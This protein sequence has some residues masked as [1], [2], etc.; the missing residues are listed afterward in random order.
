MTGE[1]R[2]LTSQ[3]K[4]ALWGKPE[5]VIMPARSAIASYAIPSG[6]LVLA[7][8]LTG[9]P[10]WISLLSGAI[11]IG[12]CLPFVWADRRR[13]TTAERA[14]TPAKRNQGRP[15]AWLFILK[16]YIEM[17][18]SGSVNDATTDETHVAELIRA[19]WSKEDGAPPLPSVDTIKQRISAFRRNKIS[20]EH[21]DKL[22]KF[23]GPKLK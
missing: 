23:I 21:A 22:H 11:A 13:H 6:A 1:T 10:G 7:P 8:I 20:K 19:N 15:A 14:Q 9:Q 2:L 17:R 4:A 5:K 12:S 3:V 18:A 16:A